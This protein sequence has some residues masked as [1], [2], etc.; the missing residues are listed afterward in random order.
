MRFLL[1]DGTLTFEA[2]DA[3]WGKMAEKMPK[4]FTSTDQYIKNLGIYVDDTASPKGHYSY[5]PTGTILYTLLKTYIYNLHSSL[6]CF[7]LETP[8]LLNY[9]HPGVK[10]QIDKAENATYH[11]E[12]IN[13]PTVT[14]VGVLYSQLAMISENG[15]LR[16]GDKYKLFEMPK[17]FRL[18]DQV[19]PLKNACE[20]TMADMHE[21]FSTLNEAMDASYV[22]HEK[23]LEFSALLDVELYVSAKVTQDFF[24]KEKDWLVAFARDLNKEISIVDNDPYMGRYLNMEYH[25]NIPD[26][27]PMELSAFQLDWD[28]PDKFNLRMTDGSIP[29]LIH[30]NFIGSVERFMYVMLVKAISKGYYDPGIAPEQIRFI[31]KT[32]GDVEFCND[33]TGKYLEHKLR[34]TIDDRFQHSIGQRIEKA[35]KEL[36]PFILVVDKGNVS[37]EKSVNDIANHMEIIDCISQ[38]KARDRNISDLV[39]SYPLLLSQWPK[40]FCSKF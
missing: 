39:A 12:N 2:N 34:V 32:E 10:N 37:L 28:N 18:E 27:K 16:K 20:F 35:T 7:F 38:S 26:D 21:L 22:I 3:V 5:T 25:I 23:I 1:P 17:V 6:G 24:E 14:K 31:P 8:T 40:L 11:I 15:R 30:S 33:L 19:I 29:T 9:D 13:T 36:I 4:R